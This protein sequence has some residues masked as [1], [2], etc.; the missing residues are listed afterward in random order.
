MNWKRKNGLGNRENK[1]KKKEEAGA[2]EKKPDQ[3]V[4]A[5]KNGPCPKA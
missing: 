4:S 2:G 1:K 5:K 3:G